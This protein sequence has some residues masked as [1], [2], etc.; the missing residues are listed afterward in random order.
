MEKEIKSL[1]TSIYYGENC[2]V[3]LMR[4][5]E[6]NVKLLEINQKEDQELEERIQLNNVK[7]ADPSHVH[8]YT[9]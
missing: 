7:N 3:E 6:A 4:R 5:A 2:W 8:F 1:N 9:L